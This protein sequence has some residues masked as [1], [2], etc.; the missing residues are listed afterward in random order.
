MMVALWACIDEIQAPLRN[1]TPRLVV[2]GIITN[3]AEPYTVR[4]T[5]TTQFANL[6]DLP[7]TAFENRAQITLRDDQGKSTAMNLVNAGLYQTADRTFVGQVGRTYTLTIR[8]SDGTV[9]VSDPETMAPVP[10]IK[11]F[12]GEY[13]GR[14]EPQAPAGMKLFVDVDDPARQRNYY[15]WN[16]SG[17]RPRSATG[18]C[19]PF[20]CFQ[21]CDKY[22]WIPF[23]SRSVPLFDDRYSDGN[24]IKRQQIYF[25][26]VY[27]IGSHSVEVRQ[28]SLTQ[29]AYQFWQRYKEQQTR[30]G[31]I[32]DPLPATIEGNV[33]RAD[34][35]NSRALGYFSASAVVIQRTRIAPDSV[36]ASLDNL[37]RE[38]LPFIGKGYCTR[39]YPD[40]VPFRPVGW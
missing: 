11:R 23:Q 19:C 39:I 1:E 27:T 14:L 24:L 2:E 37:Y 12:Y 26:P 5:Y 15:R 21:F 9:Y 36:G 13:G 6:R 32:L 10:P 35:R 8:L 29:S 31:S 17:W 28:Y 4:L 22:C 38:E 16:V 30:T 25:S 7:P 3:Q 18:D 33:A 40:A 20:N 34:N